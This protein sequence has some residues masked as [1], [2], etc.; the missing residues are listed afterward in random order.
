MIYLFFGEDNFRSR[1][2]LH[3]FLEKIKKN[4]FL[5]LF[6]FDSDTFFRPAF[7]ELVA[8]KSLFGGNYTVVCESILKDSIVADFIEKN[9]KSCADSENVF[10]FWEEILESSLLDAFKKYGGKIEEFKPL[11]LREAKLWL[12]KETEKKEIEIPAALKEE[13]MEQCGNNLWL[14]SSELE[15]YELSSKEGLNLN[16][17]AKQINVFY[18]VDAVL[19]KDRSRAWL[20]FQEAIMSGLDPEEIFWKIVWQIKNLLLIKKLPFSSE[21]KIIEM[22]NLH[23]YVVKKTLFAG[24]NFSEEELAKYSS[25]LID[26]YHNARR[27]LADFET[28]IE[29]FLIKI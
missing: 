12:N 13:L 19:E 8:G 16:K 2:R 4:N 27:G 17:K 7:E 22:T 28:G 25:E 23:P 5:S 11:S 10:V 21:K 3:E 14:L 24:R 18:I 26:L 6:F 20:L 1:Q 15:K 9:L 29:K